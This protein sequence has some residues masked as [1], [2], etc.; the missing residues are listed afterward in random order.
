MT[1]KSKWGGYVFLAPEKVVD[2]FIQT[3]VAEAMGRL[4]APAAAWYTIFVGLVWSHLCI[5]AT[6]GESLY[7]GIFSCW[8]QYGAN[9]PSEHHERIRLSRF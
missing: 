6:Y 7:H 2:F 8:C 1:S 5:T 4:A 3:H 9:T